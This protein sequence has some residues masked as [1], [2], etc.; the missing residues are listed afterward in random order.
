MVIIIPKF[1]LFSRSGSYFDRNRR[2][3]DFF[4]AMG[5]PINRLAKELK[6]FGIKIL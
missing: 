2:D 4:N 5:L 6:S 3:G 1:N